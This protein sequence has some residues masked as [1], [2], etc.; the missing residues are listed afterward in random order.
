MKTP[1]KDAE[2]SIM[3]V[4]YDKIALVNATGKNEVSLEMKEPADKTGDFVT[5]IRFFV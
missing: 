1:V 2:Q 3:A 5:E 4:D